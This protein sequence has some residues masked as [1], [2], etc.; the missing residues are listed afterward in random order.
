RLTGPDS[1]LSR[2]VKEVLE[3]GLEAELT[4]HLGYAK[5]DPAGRGSGN[6]RN[7]TTPKT[8]HTEIGPVDVAVPRDRAGTFEPVLLPTHRHPA[9][10]QGDDDVRQHPT[11]SRAPDQL[12]HR[13]RDPLLIPASTHRLG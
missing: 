1:F 9:G 10:V 12:P 3:V 4:E 8:V 7:G 11:E 13:S 2:L 6:S 5:H